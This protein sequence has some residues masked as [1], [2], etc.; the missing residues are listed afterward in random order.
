MTDPSQTAEVDYG[1]SERR[2]LAYMGVD[3]TKP[4]ARRTREQKAVDLACAYGVG[5]TTAARPVAAEGAVEET[6]LLED[7]AIT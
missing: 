5:E 7:G 3:L 1:V 2:V 4:I 6:D